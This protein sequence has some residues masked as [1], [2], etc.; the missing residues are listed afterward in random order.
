MAFYF[1]FVIQNSTSQEKMTE[2]ASP[3]LERA[4]QPAC[5][6]AKDEL[7]FDGA[8]VHMEYY[9]KLDVIQTKV[10]FLKIFLS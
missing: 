6:V 7:R 2:K 10:I 1:H 4:S 5:K 3:A 9:V 8:K